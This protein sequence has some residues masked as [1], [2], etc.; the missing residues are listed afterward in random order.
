MR[1]SLAGAIARVGL[2]A[3]VV[4]SGTYVLVYLYRWEWH[5]A[6]VA[7]LFFLAAEIGLVG[8]AVLDRLRDA[9]PKP[10][11]ATGAVPARAAGAATQQQAR[12]SAH[13]HARRKLG[14]SA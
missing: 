2:S 7:G 6:Q 11:T 12:R 4:V 3:S 1:R 5:R 13:C 14:M 9:P 10:S 8:T